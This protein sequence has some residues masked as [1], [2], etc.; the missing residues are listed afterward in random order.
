MMLILRDLAP[1]T[2][3][4]NTL[5]NVNGNTYAAGTNNLK[6]WLSGFLWPVRYPSD[7]YT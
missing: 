2:G 7:Q 6:G 5:F 1:I 3:I 4:T